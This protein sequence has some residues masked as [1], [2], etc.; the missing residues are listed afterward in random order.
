MTIVVEF[1]CKN[2]DTRFF[3]RPD[4]LGA[5]LPQCPVCV[6]THYAIDAMDQTAEAR[7]TL[8]E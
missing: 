4:E 1:V 7:P 6:G 2:C 3:K 5:G 8:S